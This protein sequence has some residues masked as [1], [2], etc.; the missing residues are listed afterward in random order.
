[1]A[2]HCI[3]GLRLFENDS[4]PLESSGIALSW[5]EAITS[6]AYQNAEPA[7]L[8]PALANQVLVMSWS[9]LAPGTKN[10]RIA[11]Y[12]RM[13]KALKHWGWD[14]GTLAYQKDRAKRLDFLTDPEIASVRQWLQGS[15]TQSMW[16]AFMLYTG[17]RVSEVQ[18]LLWRDLTD[19]TVTFVDTKGG[20][21]HA[22]TLPLACYPYTF[23]EVREDAG[24]FTWFTPSRVSALW[25]AIRRGNPTL[26]VSYSPHTLRHTCASRMVQ[27]GIPLAVIKEWLGHKSINMTMRYAHLLPGNQL[28]DAALRMPPMP[29]IP[30]S[31]GV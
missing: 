16:F 17:A 12:N 27:N 18:K 25:R 29:I 26:P 4:R 28:L 15:R 5:A 20:D 10:R 21:N 1:M 31:S 14:I 23:P 11:I 13:S 6:R 7:V 30:I 8:S 19:T 3:N 2:E 9:T 22:R 24:P